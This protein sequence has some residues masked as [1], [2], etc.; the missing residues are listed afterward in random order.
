MA[1]E[2]IKYQFESDRWYQPKERIM[3]K[4][5]VVFFFLFLGTGLFGFSLGQLHTE[6]KIFTQLRTYGHYETQEAYILCA[7]R[8][9]KSSLIYQ[10]KPIKP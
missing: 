3:H 6:H 10:I 1:L 9:N 4:E 8:E 5:I 2:T 7:V